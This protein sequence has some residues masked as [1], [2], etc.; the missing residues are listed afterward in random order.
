MSVPF[1]R[2]TCHLAT[3]RG[4]ELCNLGNRLSD[5]KN[6]HPAQ[7]AGVELIQNPTVRLW[8]ACRCCPP[9]R[10]AL[11]SPCISVPEREGF[12]SQ[13][14]LLW[15]RADAQLLAAVSLQWLKGGCWS[16]AM[17]SFSQEGEEHPVHH[18]ATATCPWNSSLALASV[19]LAWFFTLRVCAW[20]ADFFFL[21]RILDSNLLSPLSLLLLLQLLP[22]TC[23]MNHGLLWSPLFGG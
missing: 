10:G 4:S 22:W 3:G 21:N 9:W 16:L 5:T 23:V 2:C 7:D 13:S 19:R 12:R 11:T 1:Q 6:P 8:R 14:K 15:W 18:P 17:S 20:W